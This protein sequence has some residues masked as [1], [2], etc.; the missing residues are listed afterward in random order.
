MKHCSE[1]VFGNLDNIEEGEEDHNSHKEDSVLSS[2][3][4][5]VFERDSDSG[6]KSVVSVDGVFSWGSDDNRLVIDGLTFPR[7]D[8]PL[9]S[10]K[11]IRN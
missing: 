10:R 9:S 6:N 7:G 11:I 1:V 2:S 4:D 5:T 3:S 8:N